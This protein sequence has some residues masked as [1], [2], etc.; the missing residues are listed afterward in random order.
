MRWLRQ[1]SKVF[2]CALFVFVL[3]GLVY[4]SEAQAESFARAYGCGRSDSGYSIQLTNDGGYIVAGRHGPGGGGQWDICV[5]KFDSNGSLNWQKSFGGSGTDGAYSIQQTTDGGYVVAG[6]YQTMEENISDDIWVIKLG[7]DGAL[8]WQKIIGGPNQDHAKSILQTDDGGYIVAGEIDVVWGTGAVGVLKLKS[9]GTVEWQKSYGG[10]SDQQAESI[11]RTSDGGYLVAAATDSFGQGKGDIWA[12]KLSSDGTVVWQ[13]TYGGSRL[14]YAYSVQQTRDGGYIV[15]GESASFDPRP[16]G[17]FEGSCGFLDT[18]CFD[19]WVL[20]LRADGSVE[21]Q[22]L[23]GGA[24]Y[25][26]ARSI[27]QTQEGGYIIAGET[28]SYGAGGGDS[29]VIKLSSDG[30]IERQRTYGGTGGES[31]NSIQQFA[32]GEYIFTGTTDSFGVGYENIWLLKL[33]EYGRIH[34]CPIVGTASCGESITSIIGVDTN[35]IGSD[36]NILPVQGSVTIQNLNAETDTIC[37]YEG[38]TLVTPR[39]ALDWLGWLDKL[40][41]CFNHSI[42]GSPVPRCQ[43]SICPE[44]VF[45]FSKYMKKI[46]IP[47]YLIDIYKELFSLLFIER[48]YMNPES[49]L[50]RLAVVFEEVPVG[51]NLSDQLLKE[52]LASIAKCK[53]DRN[54]DPQT[55]AKLIE[56]TNAIELDLS[57]PLPIRREIPSAKSRVLN[58]NGIAWLAFAGIKKPG[59]V[60]LRLSGGLPASK[61]RFKPSWPIFFYDFSFTGVLTEKGFIDIS[62]YVGGLNIVGQLSELRIFEWDGNRYK[63]ITTSFD[64]NKKI[65]TGRTNRL[66]KYVIM[67]NSSR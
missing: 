33:D 51:P 24:N 36:A 50:A 1:A 58:F 45:L 42:S 64:N 17:A 57:V 31:A 65:I 39:S 59:H 63:D 4:V 40:K 55:L 54:T 49:S 47:E 18:G 56:A 10:N 32:S 43:P 5:M 48:H 29:W 9:D 38:L 44:C 27:Q 11:C 34:D 14:D 30:K 60:T 25:D 28:G 19:A 26:S 16:S 13:K 23:F 41:W 53:I 2:L 3:V 12:I 37:L 22:K 61:P 6:C 46:K 67:S 20:K 15:A 8:V 66:L 7:S 21:W 62:F 35:V 52:V